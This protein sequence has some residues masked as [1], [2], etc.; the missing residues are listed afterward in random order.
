MSFHFTQRKPIKERKLLDI[1]YA[2]VKVVDGIDVRV[3]GS[4]NDKQ[5]WCEKQGE[6]E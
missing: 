6:K 4:L 2:L 5:S 3:E 1:S